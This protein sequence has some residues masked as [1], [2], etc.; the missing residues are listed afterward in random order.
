MEGRGWRD[1]D[2][3][4]GGGGDGRFTGGSGSVPDCAI[5]III[6][7][8]DIILPIKTMGS[9]SR[10]AMIFHRVTSPGLASCRAAR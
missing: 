4:W 5:C 2:G 7:P 6:A 1:G 3:V 9:G 10:L 8:A